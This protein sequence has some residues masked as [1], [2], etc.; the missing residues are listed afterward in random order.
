MLVKNALISEPLVVAPETKIADFVTRVLATAQTTGVVVDAEMRLVGV[1][2]VHD[3]YRKLL[4]YFVDLDERLARLIHDTHFD[5][6]LRKIAGDPIR[7][8][9][10][11]KGIQTVEPDDSIMRALE[12][13]VH[14]GFNTVPVVAGGKFVG[15]VSRRSVLRNFHGGRGD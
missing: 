12:I 2:S 1:V 6:G 10:S 14:K 11:T 5:E 8:I 3:I 15:S 13:F 9:M 7:T 4:P